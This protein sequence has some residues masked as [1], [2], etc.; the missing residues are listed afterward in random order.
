[1]DHVQGF[2][3]QSFCFVYS[4]RFLSISSRKKNMFKQLPKSY[5]RLHQRKQIL[6]NTIRYVLTQNPLYTFFMRFNLIFIS[7]FSGGNKTL[8]LLIG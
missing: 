5:C 1:M 2:L 3:F 6:P 8:C 7:Y 4:R